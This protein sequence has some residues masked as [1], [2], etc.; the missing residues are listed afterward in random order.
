MQADA[1]YLG[2]DLS[3]LLPPAADGWAQTARCYRTRP[4]LPHRPPATA[5]SGCRCTARLP[6]WLSLPSTL[7]RIRLRTQTNI[8][9]SKPSEEQQARRSF[10]VAAKTP[11]YLPGRA[12]PE[13]AP[14]ILHVSLLPGQHSVHCLDVH[15]PGA[16][17]DGGQHALR[18]IPPP[19][20]RHLDRPRAI[21]RQIHSPQ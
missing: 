4:A 20:L 9:E 12:K 18:R 10:T 2:A 7:R 16:A 5:N 1:P 6:R 13:S 21:R 8:F 11:V 17:V 3:T 19:Q 14:V 15:Q